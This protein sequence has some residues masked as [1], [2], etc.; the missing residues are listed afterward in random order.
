MVTANTQLMV[1]HAK[2]SP[3]IT[4][5]L[6]ADHIHLQVRVIEFVDYS[7]VKVMQSLAKLMQ[8]QFMAIIPS[9]LNSMVILLNVKFHSL[10]ANH[11]Q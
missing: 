11:I 2:Y 5:N 9:C 7:M 3:A 1:K 10:V 8:I 4:H 6:R